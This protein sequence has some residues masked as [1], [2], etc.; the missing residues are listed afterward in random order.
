MKQIICKRGLAL[1]LAAGICL[2]GYGCT[3]PEEDVSSGAPSSEIVSSEPDIIV[4]SQPPKQEETSSIQAPKV[5]VVSQTVDHIQR[6]VVT[7]AFAGFAGA[8]ELNDKIRQ[9]QNADL[10]EIAE[11]LEDYFEPPE[12]PFFYRSVFDYQENGLLSVCMLNEDYTGGAHGMHWIT[13][14][15][16]D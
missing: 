13:S 1:L 16:L 12:S 5:T 7:P 3:S 8:E 9:Q 11:I 6:E 4:S 10:E 2:F 15:N 14:Y